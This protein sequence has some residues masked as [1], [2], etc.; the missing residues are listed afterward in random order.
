MH[1]V[2]QSRLTADP[3]A[4]SVFIGR[5]RRLTTGQLVALATNAEHARASAASDLD[6]WRATTAVS[7]QLRRARR[8]RPAA[9]ASMQASEA[10]LAAPGAAD[11]P[12]DGV[13][14][15][16]RA[17]ADVARALVAGGPQ[18]ALA[19]LARGWEGFVETAD[20]PPGPTAA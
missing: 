14:H 13:V 12:H 1:A 2:P 6:W 5:L 11:V 15:A 8:W 10:V 3:P 17:A 7:R 18:F 4:A 19:I 16:A 20:R 9:L